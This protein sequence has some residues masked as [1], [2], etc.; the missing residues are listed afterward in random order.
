MDFSTQLKAIRKQKGISQA[1]L[2]KIC[3]TNVINIS[4]YEIGKIKPNI[5]MAIVI[6]SALNVSLDVLCGISK[7]KDTKL[8]KLALAASKLSKE[9]TKALELIISAMVK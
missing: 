1:E 8:V 6:S 3:K 9:K 4:R 7:D 5:E 2:A